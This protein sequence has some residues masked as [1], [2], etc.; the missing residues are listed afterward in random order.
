[1]CSHTWSLGEAFLWQNNSSFLEFILLG[2]HLRTCT[3]RISGGFSMYRYFAIFNIIDS[4]ES[5]LDD[6]RHILDS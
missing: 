5:M 4:T 3:L 6:R 2:F 1:M